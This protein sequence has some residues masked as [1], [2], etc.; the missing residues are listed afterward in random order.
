MSKIGDPRLGDLLQLP[1]SG[2]KKAKVAILGYPC[3]IGVERNNGRVGS[4]NGPCCIRKKL[5]KMGTVINPEF[6]ID[7]S[8]I[9]FED[10]GDIQISDSLEN[11]HE[12]LASEVS[13]LLNDGFIVIVVGGGNDQSYP[14]AKG[15]MSSMK[16]GNIG[17]V[18]IDAHLDVRPLI[19]GSLAHSGS[20]FRQ[21]L[22]DEMY[23]KDKG[24]FLEFASQGSQC[25]AEHVKYIQS[26]SGKIVWLSEIHKKGANECFKNVLNDFKSR[27]LFVSFDID[28]ITGADCPGV[29]CPSVIGLSAQDAVDI[30]YLA[31]KNTYTKLLDLSEFNPNIEED[32][33]ARLVVN[34][35]Y[36]FLLGIAER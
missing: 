9:H 20:P 28:S 23:I 16:S 10:R 35:I 5:E 25:S 33:T 18:N 21:L 17:V 13:S 15:L 31:G 1:Y 6:N 2:N 29:S 32:R 11:N 12:I 34:M 24:M 30:C 14:N 7:L 36:Y 8:N 27:P 22:E 26:K 3:D 4:K 19:N